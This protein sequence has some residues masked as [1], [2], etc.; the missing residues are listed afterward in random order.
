MLSKGLATVAGYLG[1]PIVAGAFRNAVREVK[2]RELPSDEGDVL[3]R[4]FERLSR[5][6]IG[7]V[8]QKLLEISVVL[9]RAA[10]ATRADLNGAQVKTRIGSI[11]ASILLPQLAEIG[12]RSWDPNLL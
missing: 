8:G 3:L 4:A 5:A 11:G 1:D 2:L 7:E 12:G 9:E 6:R 10:T